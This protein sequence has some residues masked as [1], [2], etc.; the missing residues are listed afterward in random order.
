MLIFADKC[1]FF[2]CAYSKIKFSFF[3]CL[4]YL[5]QEIH[6]Y[7]NLEAGL[8]LYSDGQ[9]YNLIT[10]RTWIEEFVAKKKKKWLATLE[11]TFKFKFS[12]A[13]ILSKK[14]KI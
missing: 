10:Y 11:M 7:V 13:K 8:L 5:H 6:T 12:M 3:C 2:Y 14:T 9:I 1:L 4:N